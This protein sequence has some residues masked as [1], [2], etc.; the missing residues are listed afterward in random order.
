MKDLDQ[1]LALLPP[2]LRIEMTQHMFLK[3][4]SQISVFK[5]NFEAIEFV[6][7]C[8]EAVQYMPDDYI[9]R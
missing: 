6:L 1:L 9:V 8:I 4:I 7:S 2:S 3:A 5:M